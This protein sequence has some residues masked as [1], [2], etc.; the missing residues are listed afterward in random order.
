MRKGSIVLPVALLLAACSTGGTTTVGSVPTPELTQHF[1]CGYGFYVSDEMQTA[2]LF[3]EL[4]D[5]QAASAGDVP[6]TSQ[7][8]DETWSAR[9]ELGV[10]LFANWCDDVLEPGE[11]TPVVDETWNVSGTIE[12]M[13]LPDPG[14][15]G[16]ASAHLSGVTARDSDGNALPLGD[17]DVTNEAWGCFA[18]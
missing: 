13:S 18:G 4:T 12:I 7:L 6:S 16:T 5:F 11:P 17:L 2:G 8:T 1:G 3:V 15:C 10:D 14:T 9:L